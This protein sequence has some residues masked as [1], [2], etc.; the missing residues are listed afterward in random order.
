MG[1]SYLMSKIYKVFIMAGE[2]SGDI[3]AASL[4]QKIK[5]L[6]GGKVEFAGIGGYYMKSENIKCIFSIKDISCIGI[7]EVF[8]KLPSIYRIIKKTIDFIKDFNPDVIIAIDAQEFSKLIFKKLPMFKRVLYVAPSVWAW[9][10]WRAKKVKEYTDLLLTIFDFEEEIFKRFNCNVSYVGHPLIENKYIISASSQD[11]KNKYLINK[12]YFCLLPGSRKSEITKLLP[13][14]ISAAKILKA[15]YGYEVII[16]TPFKEVELV[17]SII[18]TENFKCLVVSNQEDKYNAISGAKFAIASSGT[19]ALELGILEI[20][21]VITYK[22]NIMTAILVKFLIK[23]K[24]VSLV[25]IIM[26]K[27][28]MP[29]LLQWDCS[30]EKILQECSYILES[31]YQKTELAKFKKKMLNHIDGVPSEIAAKKILDLIAA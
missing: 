6:T 24:W 28:I 3:L 17:N 11:F 20:P 15:R 5:L 8:K 1:C 29:E 7:F 26:N 13:I 9:R 22:A 18:Q 30:V 14:F 16:V 10:S 23:L 12:N 21:T 19:V 4:M 2:E 27:K 31:T 25:N